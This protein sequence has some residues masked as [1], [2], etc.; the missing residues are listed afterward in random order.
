M[1]A[2]LTEIVALG[3]AG[4]D[5]LGCLLMLALIAGGSRERHTLVFTGS[6]ALVT[7]GVGVACAVVFRTNMHRLARFLYGVPLPVWGVLEL[8][9]AIG[10]M[11]WGVLRLRSHAV[12][13]RAEPRRA[14]TATVAALGAGFGLAAFVDPGYTGAI[15]VSSREPIGVTVLG[16]T[17]WFLITQTPLIV[18]ALAALVGRLDLVHSAVERLVRR[19]QRPLA[20]AITGL[21][22][23]TALLLTVDATLFAATGS[24]VPRGLF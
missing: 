19:L 10:L 16:M 18:L 17:I 15:L 5:P 20:W 2:Y 22:L 11:M 24:Y 4:F 14:S 6:Q 21:I 13:E 3:V 1:G 7:I 8:V 12:D 23:I 9:V